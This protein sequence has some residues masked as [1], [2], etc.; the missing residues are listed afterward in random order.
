MRKLIVRILARLSKWAEAEVPDQ[1]GCYCP[2]CKRSFMIYL[3]GPDVCTHCGS[4][5][6][7]DEWHRMQSDHNRKHGIIPYGSRLD[8]K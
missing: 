7:F 2:D 4:T 5:A 6:Y 1:G 3:H 8:C